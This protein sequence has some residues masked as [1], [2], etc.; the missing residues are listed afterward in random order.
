M[1]VVQRAIRS[2]LSR[3]ELFHLR[4]VETHRLK[5][6][7]HEALAATLGVRINEIVFA[8]P[9]EDS[10]VKGLVELTKKRL[11]HLCLE[12]GTH[13][14]KESKKHKKKFGYKTLRI[15][16]SVAIIGAGRG[17]TFVE[18]FG[19]EIAQC[20]DKQWWVDLPNKF[21][22]C[23]VVTLADMTIRKT[24]SE[25]LS[26]CN[27]MFVHCL[28][29]HFDQCGDNSV[30]IERAFGR[31]TDCQITQSEYNGV[32][33]SGGGIL[34]L[35][36]QETKIENNG[37]GND[38][39]HSILTGKNPCPRYYGLNAQAESYIHLLSPLTKEISINN[40][41][42]QKVLDKSLKKE[43]I[44]GNIALYKAW[45]KERNGLFPPQNYT[46]SSPGVSYG[47][48]YTYLYEQA[49]F[50]T[51]ETL[52]PSY[53]NH[54]LD[55]VVYNVKS[56]GALSVPPGLGSINCGME[57]AI[58]RGINHI[59]LE[60]GT[61]IVADRLVKIEQPITISGAG[62]GV[63]FVTGAGFNIG[64]N[65]KEIACLKDMTI[66][67]TRSSALRVYTGMFIHCIRIHFDQCCTLG[68]NNDDCI[69]LYNKG[70]GRLT[71]CQITGSG[72]NGIQS[73]TGKTILQ[74]EGEETKIENNATGVAPCRK[75]KS[76]NCFALAFGKKYNDSSDCIVQI[77]SPLT[78]EG[79]VINNQGGGN[80]CEEDVDKIQTVDGFSESL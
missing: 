11:K 36:G 26:N 73:C 79:I 58:A 61:H 27:G 74:I 55:S 41:H 13:V 72:W 76:L 21:Q 63:T 75:E 46:T 2:Y 40:N 5:Q 68:T 37:T 50:G 25:G 15:E 32:K 20:R 53:K 24:E 51:I 57:Q 71:N 42:C 70:K 48:D 33:C 45:L 43:Q 16:R 22:E 80:W 44:S 54:F 9:G 39:T 64:G 78:K 17:I 49:F 14:I 4:R 6:V 69:S 28:R 7:R 67:K 77:L 52:N 29:I 19:F 1:L 34:E 30:R 3:Q 31:L 59:H 47:D 23:S 35:A 10:I 66:H 18:G 8:Y 56:N 12:P 62:R 38:P 65:N 60:A